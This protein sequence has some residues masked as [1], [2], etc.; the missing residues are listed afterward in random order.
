MN[1]HELSQ[2][3]QV[4]PETI[5]LYRKK[6]LL[7]PIV[8]P[9]NGYYEY[10]LEDMVNLCFIR[11]HRDFD[12]SL[13][14]IAKMYNSVEIQGL[15]KDYETAITQIDREIEI[16]LQKKEILL[17]ARTHFSSILNLSM[18]IKEITVDDSR[19]D[20]YEL[21]A[22]HSGQITDW[23]K[24]MSQFIVCLR[25]DPEILTGQETPSSISPKIG[26]GTYTKILK[27]NNLPIPEGVVY[28]PPGRFIYTVIELNR[29]D[30]LPAKYII[31]LKDY[32]KR[33]HLRITGENVSFLI[34]INRS[35][36]K[37]TFIFRLRIRVEDEK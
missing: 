16:L 31:S 1:I 28:C 14:D 23:L 13:H 22:E 34:R 37:E 3:V 21:D 19:H 15:D 2:I 29:L 27:E 33:H 5:R 4:N 35:S 25:I 10:T 18:E 11:K 8:N 20:Y 6:G 24:N 30:C 32:A 26:I 12:F 9:I 17:M 7:R 36:K